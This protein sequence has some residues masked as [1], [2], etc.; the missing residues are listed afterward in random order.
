MNENGQTE[1]QLAELAARARSTLDGLVAEL[2]LGI[3]AERRGRADVEAALAESKD[4]EARMRKA[5]GAL[6]GK[7]PSHAG[8]Q[9][10]PAASTG[11]WNVSE[12]R[13]QFVYEQFKAWV[14]AEPDVEHSKTK[15][16]AWINERAKERGESG[17]AGETVSKAM[18]VLRERELVRVARALRGGGKEF[19]LMPVDEHAAA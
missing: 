13:V 1:E 8:R 9:A 17:L 11:G 19:A 12:D 5:L 3:D 16:G 6:E 4:R 2:E 15:L 10:R 14:A 18:E 7:P